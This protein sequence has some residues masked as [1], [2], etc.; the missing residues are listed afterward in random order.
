MLQKAKGVTGFSAE[1][2]EEAGPL[3]AMV[4]TILRGVEPEK[5]GGPKKRRDIRRYV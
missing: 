2:S 3:N 5:K 1:M 4:Y